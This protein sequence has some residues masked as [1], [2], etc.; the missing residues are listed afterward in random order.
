VTLQQEQP[1]AQQP[2]Q[3]PATQPAALQANTPRF[4]V[5]TTWHTVIY[6]EAPAEFAEHPTLYFAD[7][8]PPDVPQQ[9]QAPL[10]PVEHEPQAMAQLPAA[11]N[12]TLLYAAGAL[13]GALAAALVVFW[14]LAQRKK[15][16]EANVIEEN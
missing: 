6:N 13:L 11:R 16:N 4:S 5:V 2:V 12:N 7:A 10:L 3:S 8:P 15:P 9:P 14:I 1:V